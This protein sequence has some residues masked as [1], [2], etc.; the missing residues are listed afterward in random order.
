MHA[1]DGGNEQPAADCT[2]CKGCKAARPAKPTLGKVMVRHDAT[3]P[4]MIQGWSDLILRH[5]AVGHWGAVGHSPELGRHRP[6]F[7][8]SA[9]ISSFPGPVSGHFP[10]FPPAPPVHPSLGPAEFISCSSPRP[11]SLQP[12]WARNQPGRAIRSPPRLVCWPVMDGQVQ[13]RGQGL[14]PAVAFRDHEVA[15]GPP[16]RHVLMSSPDYLHV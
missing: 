8:R 10:P 9:T 4:G 1:G 3:W 14:F 5:R 7:G 6:T 15:P 12:F 13:E 2:H 11:P 16:V